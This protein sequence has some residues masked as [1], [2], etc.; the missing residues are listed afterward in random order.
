MDFLKSL[1]VKHGYDEDYK[2]I[3][4]TIIDYLKKGIANPYYKVSTA[5]IEASGLLFSIFNPRYWNE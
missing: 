4:P 5:T 1:F 2:G 3:Y